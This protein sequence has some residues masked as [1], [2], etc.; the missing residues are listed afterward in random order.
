MTVN[1]IQLKINEQTFINVTSV[2]LDHIVYD[3]ILKLTLSYY[4]DSKAEPLRS[5]PIKS[6]HFDRIF[7]ANKG[8]VKGTFS[9]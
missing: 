1:G 3:C 2:F 4:L 7:Q 9:P 8:K 5:K 6:F